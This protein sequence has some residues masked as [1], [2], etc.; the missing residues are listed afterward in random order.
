MKIYLVNIYNGNNLSNIDAITNRP[1][2]YNNTNKPSSDWD[3][4]FK[5][6]SI[7]KDP[8]CQCIDWN[9]PVDIPEQC[10]IKVNNHCQN[11]FNDPKCNNLRKD[12]CKKQKE[13]PKCNDSKDVENLK[14]ELKN[15]KQQVNSLKNI[16]YQ[17]FK[18]T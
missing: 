9:N 1:S 17:N 8:A 18:I 14:T 16:R 12:K 13:Q 2:I 4:P 6:E 10:K 11:N 3:C 5:D 7:C 15:M